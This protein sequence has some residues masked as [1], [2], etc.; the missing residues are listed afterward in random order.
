[1]GIINESV[2]TKF[3]KKLFNNKKVSDV[4]KYKTVISCSR[5]EGREENQDYK[6]VDQKNG[7]FIISD[8][9]GGR[10][11]N[12]GGI[13]SRI[14]SNTLHF[15]IKD[16]RNEL[17]LGL[18]KKDKI[19]KRIKAKINYINQIFYHSKK[20]VGEIRNCGATVDVLFV[21]DGIAYISHV[22][23]SSVSLINKKENSIEKI[24]DEHIGYPDNFNS[25]SPI[26][27]EVIT[28]HGGLTSYV[29][30]GDEI[31]I[32]TY[33]EN[34]SDDKLILMM[35][36]GFHTVTQEEILKII[37]TTNQEDVRENMLAKARNPDEIR[38]GYD[39]LK[40]KG[41]NFDLNKKTGDNKS[42]ILYCHSGNLLFGGYDGKK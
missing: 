16:L 22:G 26:E 12:G 14:T 15:E 23:D 39:K 29:S 31:I 7:I 36:D 33:Q 27:K 2:I 18:T 11:H 5:K 30:K 3:R 35:T 34:L 32:D 42:F 28:L 4:H 24:T 13:C 1:M 10:M 20:E 25:F 17:I 19:T 6:I 38:K 41:Y 21:Y 40:I 9:M 8:G 37:G